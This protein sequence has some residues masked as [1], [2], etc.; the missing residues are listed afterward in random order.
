MYRPSQR[1]IDQ[2]ARSFTY[3]SPL[4]VEDI[5]K[6]REE[7]SITD[8]H[9]ISTAV[10]SQQ[11]RYVALRDHAKQ[12]A[13]RIVESTPPSREQALALTK[14]EECVMWANAAIARNE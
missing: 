6:R 3:H 9:P 8:V 5:E 7:E 12:L 10:R 4:S 13:I 11:D 14:L 2:I 1:I